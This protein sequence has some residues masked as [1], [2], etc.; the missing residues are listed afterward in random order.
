MRPV[1]RFLLTAGF[2]LAT[3]LPAWAGA[4]D[5]IEAFKRG[6]HA[7]ALSEWRPLADQGDAQAQY[8]LG[9]MRA[10]GLGARQD[11][12]EAAY[13]LRAAAD[14]GYSY[15]QFA[16]GYLFERG[17]GVPKDY[18]RAL[19]YY[20]SAA[21]QGLAMAHNNIGVMYEY[22]RGVPWDYAR[23]YQPKWSSLMSPPYEF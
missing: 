3:A 21:D 20:R 16:L 5:A 4:E 2:L 7:L 1:R 11:Y 12:A 15:G 18:R 23:A 9:H 8:F 14:Q 22:G 17:L 19:G 10:E 6:D 13:W